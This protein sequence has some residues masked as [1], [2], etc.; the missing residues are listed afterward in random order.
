LSDK[1]ETTGRRPLISHE[2]RKR[3]VLAWLVPLAVIIAIMVLLPKVV[4]LLGG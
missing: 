4:G 1:N 2:H 3:S